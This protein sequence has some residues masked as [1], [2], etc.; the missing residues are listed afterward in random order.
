VLCNH[1]ASRTGIK[2][3]EKTR[4]KVVRSDSLL[5][6]IRLTLHRI[7]ED[8]VL[9]LTAR[10]TSLLASVFSAE[11]PVTRVDAM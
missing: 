4:S 6:A 1:P 5:H 7:K 8:T 11:G 10:E 9:Y 3:D 2:V